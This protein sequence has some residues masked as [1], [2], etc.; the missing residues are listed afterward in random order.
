MTSFCGLPPPPLPQMINGL[1]S[2]IDVSRFE[3][4]LKFHRNQPKFFSYSTFVP[5]YRVG[6]EQVV[7]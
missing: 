6:R 2:R 4:N 5:S 1:K 3:I 7:R